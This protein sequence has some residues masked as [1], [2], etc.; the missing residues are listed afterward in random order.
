[1]DLWS[2]PDFSEWLLYLDLELY[3]LMDLIDSV[4]IMTTQRLAHHLLTVKLKGDKRKS[5]ENEISQTVE[6]PTYILKLY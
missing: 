4:S 3:S 1:M 6:Y 5:Q 2:V